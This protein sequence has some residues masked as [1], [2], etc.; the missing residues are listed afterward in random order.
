MKKLFTLILSLLPITLILGQ[1]KNIMVMEIKSEIDAPMKRYVDLA[2]KHASETKAEIVIIEMDTYGGVLTDAKEIVDLIMKHKSPV[3]VYINSDAAS[4]G[5]LISIA[6]DSIYMSPGASI[7]AATVVDGS[8]QKA[9]DKYQ[10]YMRSIMRATAEENGR[11]PQIAEGMVDE[12]LVIEGIKK[13]GQIITF[14]TSEA[15]QHGFCDAKVESIEEILK[16]NNISNYQLDRF[17]LS[18]ADR[19]IAFFLNPFIS[20]LLILV[21]IAGIY[22]EMQTPGIGFAGFAALVALI[23][24]LVPYYLNGLAENWEIIAFFIG[25]ILIAVEVFVLPGFGVAGISGIILT[26]GSLVL[27]MINN[28][29]FDFEFVPLN[30]ITVAV[31][32]ALGGFLGGGI[33]LFALGSRISNTRFYSKVA[34]TETQDRKAGYTASSYDAS[35]VGTRGTAHTILRPSGRVMIGDRI[36]DAYTRGEF[37]EKGETIE[38]ISDEGTSLKVKSV[39][40]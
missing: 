23:L 25:I 18:G 15:I 10:S 20:G 14:S 40:D 16:R 7:G 4:A 37:I 17:Q 34:L 21:I 12:N 8:G 13:E 24:Y 36:F 5:A 33:L 28:D 22:F 1:Q 19:V 26:L 9:P 3:W 6:C 11:N 38:V 31:A 27:I 32:A 35:M 39:Q 29:T 30:N 2:L